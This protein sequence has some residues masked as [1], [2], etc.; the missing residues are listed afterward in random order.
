MTDARVTDAKAHWL[1]RAPWFLGVAAL[2]ASVLP[3]VAI[4]RF[5]HPQADDYC[6][7]NSVHE[8]GFWASQ[9]Y[10][11]ATWTGRFVSTALMVAGPLSFG[12]FR[13][14][15][16][17]PVVLLV[18]LG[19]ALFWLAYELLRGHVRTGRIAALALASLAVYLDRMASPA[20]GIYWYTGAVVYTV[21]AICAIATIAAGLRAVRSRG[22]MLAWIWAVV[23]GVFATLAAGGNEPMLLLL[24]LALLAFAW[25]GRTLA[26][27]SWRLWVVPLVFATLA[28]AVDVLAPGNFKRAQASGGLGHLIGPL[29]GSL[30]LSG[31]AIVEWLSSG[32]VLLSLAA[33]A[34]SGALVSGRLEPGSPW[35]S[36]SW[37]WP[38]A[39]A[40]VG[41]WGAFFFT[42]WASG[43]ALRPGPPPRVVN[44]VLL[45]FLLTAAPC[46][47][48]FGV[49][50]LQRL[51]APM[52]DVQ[53]D[54]G[55]LLLLIAVSIF[56]IG[57]VRQAYV[58]LLAGRAGAYDREL[59]ARYGVFR[60][61]SEAGT[62]ATVPALSRLPATLFMR[63]IMPEADDWRNVCVARFW[64][65]PAVR[66]A[67]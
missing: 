56:G 36:V 41:V 53:A 46:A 62:P 39:V 34:L 24:G 26:M 12:S 51:S 54:N 47:F 66:R 6:T 27:A 18:A 65:V 32:P 5:A 28:G 48:M 2:L 11:Y 43:I 50:R 8:L 7:A 37:R 44:V 40:V 25:L 57:N 13:M 17:V 14:Y 52:S 49:Q 38:G 1:G 33:L 3:F 35:R 42:H 45:F 22:G 21:P 15:K 58:D 55:W 61:A 30:A 60:H 63:D 31:A 10:W 19:L 9:K 67:P 16:L 29:V 4:A 23:S 20:E 59:S 64:R